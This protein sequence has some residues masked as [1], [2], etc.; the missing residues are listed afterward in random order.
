MDEELT[1]KSYAN[2]I[3]EY[4]MNTSCYSCYLG[5]GGRCDLSRPPEKWPTYDTDYDDT[6]YDEE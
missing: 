2:A 1:L 4:C 3:K 6:D 5:R